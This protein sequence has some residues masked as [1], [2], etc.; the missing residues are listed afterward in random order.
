MKTRSTRSKAAKQHIKTTA[1]HASAHF[2]GGGALVL[3]IIAIAMISHGKLQ[4]TQATVDWASLVQGAST[5]RAKLV[6]T[7]PGPDGLTGLVISGTKPG[8]T[9]VIGWGIPGSRPAV[10]IASVYT[11][12][13]HDLT[14]SA[15]A[16]ELRSADFDAFNST[17]VLTQPSA[18]PTSNTTAP[19]AP[20]RDINSAIAALNGV[21]NTHILT[22][23]NF[24]SATSQL[25]AVSLGHGTPK[26]YVYF[27]ANCPYCH[28]LY[29]SLKN[30]GAHFGMHWIPVAILSST[31][32]PRGAAILDG[33]APALAQNENQFSQTSEEGGIAPSDDMNTAMQVARNTLTLTESG[34]KSLGTPTLVWKDA[35]GVH[36]QVG[37]PSQTEL[38]SIVSTL[39]SKT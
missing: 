10:V 34:A 11:D 2:L 30:Q 12:D 35:K 39:E 29:V 33:G 31:S 16:S 22:P 6:K 3:A 25:P 27:D 4:A 28:S 14:A 17:H 26:L 24:L 19:P 13:G 21:P 32:G 8:A 36:I 20:T 38:A 15:T 5:G 1:L 23:D 37:M 18:V 7:F 9:P